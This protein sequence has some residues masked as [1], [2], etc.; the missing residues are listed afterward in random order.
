MYSSVSITSLSFSNKGEMLA[1]TGKI[2]EAC[3]LGRL[4][5]KL[6]EKNTSS[7]KYKSAVVLVVYQ[8]IFWYIEPLQSVAE[9]HMMGYKAGLQL[10]DLLFSGWNLQ[11]SIILN[12]IGGNNLIALQKA[13]KECSMKLTQKQSLFPGFIL[14]HSQVTALT[15]GLRLLDTRIIDNIPTEAEL[16]AKVGEEHAHF[17]SHKL[18]RAFLFRQFNDLLDEIAISELTAEAKLSLRPMLYMRI[19]F[20]GLACFLC[21]REAEEPAKTALIEKGQSIL[22]E[23]RSLAK[24]SSWNWQNKV[25]LLEAMNN[26][27]IGNPEEA[28]Q[29]YLSSIQSAREHKFI[30]EEAVASELTAEYLFEM[31]RQAEAYEVYNHSIKCFEEWGAQAVVNRVKADVQSKF[32]TDVSH[33]EATTN[34]DSIL[35]IPSIQQTTQSQKKRSSYGNSSD[36]GSKKTSDK[37]TTVEDKKGRKKAGRGGDERMNLAF[38]LKKQNPDMSLLDA[39]E[40]GGFIFPNLHA[41]G[42]K[43]SQVKD[44]DDILLS[45]RKN[46]LNRRLREDRNRKT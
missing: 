11:L 39:L 24:H 12:Y 2:E 10:G 5:L 41:D 6:V 26:H 23:A 25:L 28:E 13:I 17:K 35:G 15:Q 9:S 21:S 38:Q 4:A 40:A 3:R 22:R 43:T 36:V 8:T 7:L 16:L 20:E 33:L 31:G 44:T 19:L 14:L 29:L 18:I 45:Q 32:G 30:H 34:I 37:G 42:V 1:S 27:T 46:Q